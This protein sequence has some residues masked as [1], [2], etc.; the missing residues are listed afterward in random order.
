[1]AFWGRK[2]DFTRIPVAQLQPGMHI[3]LAERWWDHPFLLNEFTLENRQQIQTITGIGMSHVLWSRDG[4]STGPL[5]G[6]PSLHEEPL[7][8][9]VLAQERTQ[10]ERRRE[11]SRRA[12]E[13]IR[14]AARNHM[15][16]SSVLREALSKLHA[17]PRSAVQTASSVVMKAAEAFAGE[18]NVS[19]VLLDDRVSGTRLRT[20][21]INVM[22]LSMM[23]GRSQ[24]W[25]VGPLG[26][27]GLGGL[28]HDAGLLCIPDSL[29]MRPESE[30]TRIERTYIQEHTAL[31]TTMMQG[32]PEFP[33]GAQ[34]VV[35]MHH[36]HWDGSGYP[37][38]L[39]GEKIPL[40]ARYAAVANR[41]DELCHP[42]SLTGACTPA[43]ALGR[44]FKIENAHFDPTLLTRFIKSMG[45]YPPGSLVELSNGAVGLVTGINRDHTLRPLVMLWQEGTKSDDAPVIDLTI[46]PELSI[47]RGLRESDLEPE[48][49]DYLN[50]RL[51]TAY[52]YARMD[53]DSNPTP[54]H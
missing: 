17:A 15:H 1:M 32:I 36:E 29:R 11:Q 28:F 8:P 13:R 22:L 49:R 43:E 42:I 31:G 51:R 6:S 37:L 14:E 19:I 10:R 30:W 18:G 50:P 40:P 45:I 52:F 46:E 41:Y 3:S 44:M 20:H 5:E 47:S 35:A 54:T 12:A 25:G 2:K 48:V 7:Q 21:A 16:A 39:A 23:L 38:K 27:L 9:E 33:P 34:A 53:A 4:S 24:R 26:E